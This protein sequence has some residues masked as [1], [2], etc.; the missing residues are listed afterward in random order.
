MTL[1]S[2]IAYV[3][4]YTVLSII[5]GPS[6]LMVIAQALSRGIQTAMACILGDLAGGVVIMAASYLGL[7]MILASSSM[8]FLTLKW[9]GVGYMAYLGVTQIIA[10]RHLAEI[11]LTTQ[12]KGGFRAGFVTGLLNP[13]AIMFY[14]AFLAQFIDPDAPQLS[15][16]L[17]LM[18]TSTIV[19]M[20]VLTAY[21]LLASKVSKRLQTIRARKGLAYAGGSC[22]LGGS[23]LM[24]VTR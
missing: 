7:G 19:V 21:A 8:A 15:Q 24:A 12:P 11:K 10:A 16:F 9:L 17:I 3:L 22:L 23:A 18:V 20:V 6:V 14:M 2:W 5:P 13:K 4:A 1:E